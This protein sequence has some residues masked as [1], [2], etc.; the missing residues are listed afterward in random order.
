MADADLE[1]VSAS[2]ESVSARP[3]SRITRWRTKAEIRTDRLARAGGELSE[4]QEAQQGSPGV[5]A[6]VT[7]SLADNEPPVITAAST[8]KLV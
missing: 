8:G 3:Y 2:F 5:L 4:T 1:P 6:A 7:G